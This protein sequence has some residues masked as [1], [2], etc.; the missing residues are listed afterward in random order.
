MGELPDKSI[1]DA[2]KSNQIMAQTVR[3]IHYKYPIQMS[4]LSVHKCNDAERVVVM[5]SRGG[6]LE[7]N[8]V[9]MH[10]WW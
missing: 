9:A 10:V 4:R 3:V 2:I 1:P 5:I 6:H 7:F 8:Q